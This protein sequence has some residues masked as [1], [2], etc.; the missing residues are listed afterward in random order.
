MGH[1]SY[2]SANA[3]PARQWL[4]F[5]VLPSGRL[6]ITFFAAT[7]Q[8]AVAAAHRLWDSERDAREAN[9]QR[10]QA[11]KPAKAGTVVEPSPVAFGLLPS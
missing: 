4:A 8:E 5:L 11:R 6:P 9:H 3:V 7:E 1:R 2:H 10:R